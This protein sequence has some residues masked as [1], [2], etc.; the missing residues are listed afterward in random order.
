M[1]AILFARRT[2][3]LINTKQ[4]CVRLS[5]NSP[6]FLRVELGLTFFLAVDEAT[7]NVVVMKLVIII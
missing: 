4:N 6:S 7:Q 3:K 1:D 2:Q 5:F